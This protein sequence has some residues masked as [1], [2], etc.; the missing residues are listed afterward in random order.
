VLDELIDRRRLLGYTIDVSEGYE[1]GDVIQVV[2]FTFTATDIELDD[3]TV[4]A[5]IAQ[6]ALVFDNDSGL[7]AAV[8]TNTTKDAID[9]VVASGERVVACFTLRAADEELVEGWS[10]AQQGV[11]ETGAS[12]VA[13]YAGDDLYVKE[14]LNEI[15]RKQDS[16]KRVY[17]AFTL[18]PDWDG[19]VDEGTPY[20]PDPSNEDEPTPFYQPQL[21]FLHHLP[22]KSDHDYSEDPAVDNTPEGARWE[23]RP[24]LAM[25]ALPDD[26]GRYAKLHTLSSQVETLNNLIDGPG[27]DQLI[28][29]CEWSAEVRPLD[30]APGAMIT[31]HGAPQHVLAG[32]DFTPLDDDPAVQSPQD[33][34]EIVLTVAMEI[35]LHV[36]SRWPTDDD[37]TD[38]QVVRRLIVDLGDEFKQHYVVPDTIWDVKEDGTLQTTDGGFI[39]DDSDALGRV[40]RVAYEWYA[41][42]RQSIKLQFAYITVRLVVGDLI[43]TIGSDESEEQINSVVTSLRFDF[44]EHEGVT[45]AG[46]LTTIT[47]GFA[48]LDPSHLL[49]HGKSGRVL[50]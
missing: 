1:G 6:K 20:F 26:S 15:A 39:R 2:P 32:E 33:W 47:T 37:L 7:K 14:K 43:T 48:E 42:E 31:V 25:I 17:A 10:D 13:E 45:P 21:R 34:Q 24:L 40:A 35:D 11:Y 50:N 4:S 29:G 23:Y 46:V 28:P 49:S 44:P 36:E 9:Q 5:N 3:F 27:D 18:P 30:D 12:E 16:V 19:T 22:F 38:T 8:L 41:V